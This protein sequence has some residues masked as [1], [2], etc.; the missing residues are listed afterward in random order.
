MYICCEYIYTYSCNIF[1]IYTSL[2]FIL[3]KSK[4]NPKILGTQLTQ[5]KPVWTQIVVGEAFTKNQFQL[6]LN[7]FGF[8]F[9]HSRFGSLH[10]VWVG[11]QLNNT[12]FEPTRLSC[13]P[14]LHH[15]VLSSSTL[16]SAQFLVRLEKRLLPELGMQW[17]ARWLVKVLAESLESSPGA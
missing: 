12:Q 6:G 17:Y 3:S 5:V 7:M 16:K 9:G 8:H 10:M 14:T 2:N 11:P 4:P 15:H 1:D 13:S